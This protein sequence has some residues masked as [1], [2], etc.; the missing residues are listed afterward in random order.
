MQARYGQQVRD[1]RRAEGILH[2]VRQ[3]ALSP[4]SMAASR[5]PKSRGSQQ[6]SSAEAFFRSP[7]ECKARGAAVG[8]RFIAAGVLALQ[9][10]AAA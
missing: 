6:R 8:T 1:A 10:D 2:G 7:V 9:Q 5:P 3:A 4:N